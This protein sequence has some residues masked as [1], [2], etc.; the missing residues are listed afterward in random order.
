MESARGVAAAPRGVQ[1]PRGPSI[2]FT[3]AAVAS[4]RLLIIRVAEDWFG[5]RA[6]HSDIVSYNVLDRDF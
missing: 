4:G 1:F 5:L 6:C 3:T 2:R